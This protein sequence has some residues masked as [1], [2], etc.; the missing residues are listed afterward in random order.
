MKS[1][2]IESV[3]GTVSNPNSNEIK[4]SRSISFIPLDFN[5]AVTPW[6]KNLTSPTVPSNETLPQ[7]SSYWE[8]VRKAVLPSHGLVLRAIPSEDDLVE[9]TMFSIELMKDIC[10]DLYRLNNHNSLIRTFEILY[11]H[12]L[13][14]YIF[15]SYVR[16]NSLI[17]C[18][19]E[20]KQDEENPPDFN[21]FLTEF[22]SYCDLRVCKCADHVATS[23]V[24][25]MKYHT[26]LYHTYEKTV[27]DKRDSICLKEFD[28]IMYYRF[29][30]C[31]LLLR[32]HCYQRLLIEVEN[33]RQFLEEFQRD[34]QRS[35]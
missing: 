6:I 1:E 20:S 10:H 30:I 28:R 34:Y 9:Q 3:D 13:T 24:K 2:S 7:T 26:N 17:Q 35:R 14:F 11:E 22:H 31:Q 27:S 16:Q 32:C 15:Q 33:G 18:T 25:L 29:A 8:K 19:H 21:Q 4:T 5:M 12:S 23:Y